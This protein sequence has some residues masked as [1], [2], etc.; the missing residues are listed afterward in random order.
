LVVSS[1]GF[2][3]SLLLVPFVADTHSSRAILWVILIVAGEATFWIG[4]LIVGREVMKRVRNRFW[5]KKWS[6]RTNNSEL[7]DDAPAVE[8]V[9]EK[10]EDI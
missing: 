8:P 6:L 3:A 1:I 4:V 9:S 2:W 10:V 5:P 7:I